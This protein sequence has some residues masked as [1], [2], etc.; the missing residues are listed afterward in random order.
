MA[1]HRPDFVL[2]SGSGIHA[3]RVRRPATAA[4]SR[5]APTGRTGRSIRGKKMR[6]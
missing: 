4:T 3:D 1:R 5:T 2:R 6:G